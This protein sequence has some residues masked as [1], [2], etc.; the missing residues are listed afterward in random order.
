MLQSIVPPPPPMPPPPE[1]IDPSETRP[2]MDPYGRAKTVRIGKWRWPPPKDDNSD[3]SFLQFKM[4]QQRRK[5][6]QEFSGDVQDGVEW[7]EFELASEQNSAPAML[8]KSPENQPMQYKSLDATPTKP[9]AAGSIGKLRISNEMKHKLEL[10]TANHSLRSTSKTASR[11]SANK[12]DSDRR[13]LLQQQ[14]GLLLF[15]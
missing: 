10:V 6:S 7:E 8:S 3:T 15:H 1:L 12:L 9:S 5:H 13:L 14:L 2:F 4:K 11:P